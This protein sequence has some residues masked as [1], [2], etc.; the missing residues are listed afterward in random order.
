MG[1]MMK[2][3]PVII[4]SQMTFESYKYNS[5]N[6]FS[7]GRRLQVLFAP[8][9]LML[10]LSLLASLGPKRPRVTDNPQLKVCFVKQVTQ[11]CLW[12]TS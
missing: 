4:F 5:E 8:Y 2:S 11:V 6:V 12:S 3:T 7:C 10:S 1:V 9:R